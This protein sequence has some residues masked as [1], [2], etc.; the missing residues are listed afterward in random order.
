MIERDDARLVA[1]DVIEG[2]E[3]FLIRELMKLGPRI[4]ALAH[5]GELIGGANKN[6]TG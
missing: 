2:F 1:N 5:D 3:S 6:D 4:E